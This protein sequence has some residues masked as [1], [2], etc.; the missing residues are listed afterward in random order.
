VTCAGGNG[1][2][3]NSGGGSGGSVLIYTQNITGLGHFSVLGGIGTGLG[4]DGAGGRIAIH[5]GWRY[6]FHGELYDGGGNKIHVVNLKQPREAASH[7]LDFTTGFGGGFDPV[8][9]MYMF[10]HSFSHEIIM[11]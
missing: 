5:S 8:I 11:S 3:I 4:Y 7:F 10:V 6:L 1:S 9:Y 2:G